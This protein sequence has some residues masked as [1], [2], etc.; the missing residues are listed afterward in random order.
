MRIPLPLPNFLNPAE[1][2]AKGAEKAVGK[3]EEFQEKRYFS[4]V[5]P[6]LFPYHSR[7]VLV[8]SSLMPPF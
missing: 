6:V 1:F 4:P 3:H 7:I 5:I 2:V 8:S